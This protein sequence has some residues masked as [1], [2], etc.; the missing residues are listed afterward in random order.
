MSNE[1]LDKL[2]QRKSALD[3]SI[4]SATSKEIK[5]SLAEWTEGLKKTIQEH[6]D[7]LLSKAEKEVTLAEEANK[8]GDNLAAMHHNTVATSYMIQANML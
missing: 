6:R 4:Y 2:R 5:D 1:R 8:R 7:V 3:S